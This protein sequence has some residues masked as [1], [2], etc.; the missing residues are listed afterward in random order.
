VDGTIIDNLVDERGWEIVFGVG[1]FYRECM[2]VI[3]GKYINDDDLSTGRMCQAGTRSLLGRR[4]RASSTR[5][6]YAVQ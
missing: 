5:S 6:E 1:M 2:L 3:D 4:C